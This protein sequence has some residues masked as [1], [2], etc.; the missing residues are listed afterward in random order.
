MP[1]PGLMRRRQR[2]LTHATPGGLEVCLTGRVEILVAGMA[3]DLCDRLRRTAAF[4]NPEFFERER[5]RLSTH[6]TPRV[7]A[8]HEDTGA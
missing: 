5:A 2:Q 8:C 3:P 7:I 1:S 4:A 6:R